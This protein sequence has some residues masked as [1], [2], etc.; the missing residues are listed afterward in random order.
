MVITM[1]TVFAH[2]YIVLNGLTLPTDGIAI[3]V[4]VHIPH[5]LC[6]VQTLTDHIIVLIGHMLGKIDPATAHQFCAEGGAVKGDQRV[7]TKLLCFRPSKDPTLGEG[8]FVAN[9]A[10]ALAV[11]VGVEVVGYHQI[12]A[13]LLLAF[14]QRI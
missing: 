9:G 3:K 1:L 11:L 5:P 10:V 6:L 14:L 4:N 8:V 12:D 7:E 13:A 2:T